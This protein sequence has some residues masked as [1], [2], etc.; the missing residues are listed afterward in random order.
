MILY[1]A[2]IVIAL[3][4]VGFYPPQI[5]LNPSLYTYELLTL[6]TKPIAVAILIDLKGAWMIYTVLLVSTG[7]FVFS[8]LY[9]AFELKKKQFRWVLILF[10]FRILLLVTAG[11]IFW[12][13]VGW[14]GLGITSF[15]L[16]VFY[17]SPQKVSR[18]ILTVLTNRIGDVILLLILGLLYPTDL[19]G[20]LNLPSW[21]YWFLVRAALTKRAQTPF[22]SW[23]PAAMAAPTPVSALVHSSTLVTAGVFVLIRVEVTHRRWFVGLALF[24][25]FLASITALRVSDVKTL[26]ALST[27]SQ[28]RFMMFSLG[29]GQWRLAFLHLVLHAIYK[30]L[31]FMVGGS[32][33]YQT[34]HDQDMRAQGARS[35]TLIRLLI[36][37]R[38]ALIAL[39]FLSAAYSKEQM[40][41]MGISRN[42]G[43]S[44]LAMV[45]VVSFLSSLYTF[46]IIRYLVR[47]HSCQTNKGVLI[48]SKP[49]WT[50]IRLMMGG[51]GVSLGAYISG[52]LVF[53][54]IPMTFPLLVP[55]I[56]MFVAL[57]GLVA[58]L[59]TPLHNGS[60]WQ[61]RSFG[62][63]Y[64]H[65]IA[66]L[67]LNLV[68]ENLL[69]VDQGYNNYFLE[70][71]KPYIYYQRKKRLVMGALIWGLAI[72]RV[73]F[74]LKGICWVSKARAANNGVINTLAFRVKDLWLCT[75]REPWPCCC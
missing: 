27:L 30:A 41:K 61:L 3:G 31:L 57:R 44:I 14:D 39:P 28:L 50:K 23:L 70:K 13:I 43:M 33:I 38:F 10:V 54:P 68:S 49:L 62:Q 9:I 35:P 48:I 36:L 1:W 63:A 2:P 4:I 18:G 65:K 25:V 37:T 72:R 60:L 29:M 15:L 5:A 34:Q 42:S 26:I 20:S 74:K 53:Y 24:T 11:N 17:S 46:R 7:V 32:L 67:S 56:V 59:K 58:R 8:Q 75:P 51:L 71:T 64:L 73:I 40:I 69:K 52:L 47:P 19:W 21:T 45:L 12:I 16:I 55:I 66:P 22:R 6:G